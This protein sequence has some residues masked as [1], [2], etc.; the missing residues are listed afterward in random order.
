MPKNFAICLVCPKLKFVTN[1]T[2]QVTCKRY[3]TICIQYSIL[4]PVL[5]VNTPLHS[6]YSF[7]QSTRLDDNLNNGNV[8]KVNVGVLQLSTDNLDDQ[9][10]KMSCLMSTSSIKYAMFIYDKCK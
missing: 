5:S 3:S 4:L 2:F 9:F 10:Y 8:D 6:L 1:I 7:G